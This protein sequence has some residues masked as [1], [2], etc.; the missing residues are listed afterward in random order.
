MS[1]INPFGG[2]VAGSSQA[3]R[4]QSADK[5]RQIRRAR[6]QSHNSALEEDEPAVE[7]QSPDALAP[8]QDRDPPPNHPKHDQP[9]PPDG[10]PAHLDVTG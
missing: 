5:D 8:I 9:P 10:E 6:R 1:Q 7:V 4:I 2:N 3:L